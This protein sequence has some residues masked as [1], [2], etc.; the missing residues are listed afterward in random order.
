LQKLTAALA[1]AICIFTYEYGKVY[2]WA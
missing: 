2:N 1:A